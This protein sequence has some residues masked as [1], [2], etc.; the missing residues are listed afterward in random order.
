LLGYDPDAPGGCKR[1]AGAEKRKEEYNEKRKKSDIFHYFNLFIISVQL[2]RMD[3]PTSN[4][5]TAKNASADF[6]NI[7]NVCRNLIFYVKNQTS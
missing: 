1:R 4:S 5:K 7:F 2:K 6:I 3:Q